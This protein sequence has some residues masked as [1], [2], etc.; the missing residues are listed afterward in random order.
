MQPF[1]SDVAVGGGGREEK[2]GNAF[3]CK[4]P[5]ESLPALAERRIDQRLAGEREQVERHQL[6]GRFGGELADAALGRME[7]KL[8]RFERKHVTGR[9]D[10][11]AV[12]EELAFFHRAKHLHH[13]GEIAA[14]RL[15]RLGG[16]RDFISVTP[17]QTAETVPLG[18]VLPAV[19]GR[20]LGREQRFHRRQSMLVHWQTIAWRSQSFRCAERR[21]C[22]AGGTRGR[23]I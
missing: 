4:E 1:E 11:L 16:Q 8:E 14:E 20:Q 22:Y 10:Q 15:A 18:F 23:N 7:P 2:S 3:L 13:L 17:S 19:A 9:D 21:G 12:E 6:G 5:L